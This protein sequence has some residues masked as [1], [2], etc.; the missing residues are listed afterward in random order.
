MYI[1]VLVYTMPV[2]IRYFVGLHIVH[3]DVMVMKQGSF[4]STFDLAFFNSLSLNRS[5]C[6]ISELRLTQLLEVNVNQNA[7]V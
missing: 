7:E 4:K 2:K 6:V 3:T 5:P 1:Y